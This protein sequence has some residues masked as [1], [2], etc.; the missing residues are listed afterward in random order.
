VKNT[1]RHMVYNRSLHTLLYHMAPIINHMDVQCSS[2]SVSPDDGNIRR[3]NICREVMVVNNKKCIS[4][5]FCSHRD[6]MLYTCFQ[7]A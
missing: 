5:G 6:P 2:Q 4:W 3:R 7:N 1:G